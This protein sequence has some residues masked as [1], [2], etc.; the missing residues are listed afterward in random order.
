M[1][2]L[3]LAFYEDG[4]KVGYADG[5]RMR[6]AELYKINCAESDDGSPQDPLEEQMLRRATVAELRKRFGFSRS[7]AESTYDLSRSWRKSTRAE[8][9]EIGRAAFIQNQLAVQMPR[10]E[11]V[12]K[13]QELFRLSR[14]EA[15]ASYDKYSHPKEKR[16]L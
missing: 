12:A 4:F 16:P 9:I 13:L 14:E 1:E 8:C 3:G 6:Y 10:E 15:E 7:D 11:M 5:V 2:G